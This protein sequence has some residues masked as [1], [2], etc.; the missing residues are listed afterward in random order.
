MGASSKEE[1]IAGILRAG[2]VM[3][4]GDASAIREFMKRE[5][6]DDVAF[7]TK[8]T[9]EY[10][11]GEAKKV[12]ATNPKYSL[13]ESDLRDPTAAFDISDKMATITVKGERY[14]AYPEG[15]RWY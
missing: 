13:K 15:G 3:R 9:D 2:A 7:W 11:L 12:I 1:I 10:V 6:P 8:A 14:Y 5:Y 4:S